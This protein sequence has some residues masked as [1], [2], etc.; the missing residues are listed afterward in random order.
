MFIA[1]RSRST[2]SICT[3]AKRRAVRSNRQLVRRCVLSSLL[4]TRRARHSPLKQRRDGASSSKNCAERDW[5]HTSPN[6]PTLEQRVVQSVGQRPRRCAIATRLAACRSDSRIM[7]PAGPS[8][9]SPHDGAVAKGPHLRAD[10]VASTHA[11]AA[12]PAR[13]GGPTGA[14]LDRR[15][16]ISRTSGPSAGSPPG[17]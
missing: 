5:N 17:S 13:V 10:R 12:L 2:T 1:P 6:R 3:Q 11:R 14:S 4:S 7:D 9:R 16:R 8:R 15:T